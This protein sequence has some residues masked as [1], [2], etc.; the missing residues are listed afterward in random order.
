M[1]FRIRQAIK[2]DSPAIRKLVRQERLNPMGLDWRN[3]IVAVTTVEGVIGCGQVKAHQDG[4]RELASIVVNREWRNNGIAKVIINQLITSYQK[5]LWLTCR[6][7]LQ[8]FYEQ[9]GFQVIKSEQMSPYFRRLNHLFS[10]YRKLSRAKE[11]LLIMKL[12]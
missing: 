3:F 9:F 10:I 6:S 2:A 11:T 4:S 8:E 12:P 5:P 7:N 1:N